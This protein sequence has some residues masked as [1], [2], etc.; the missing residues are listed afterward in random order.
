MKRGNK[1]NRNKAIGGILVGITAAAI[2]GLVLKHRA[3]ASPAP[4]SKVYYGDLRDR[5][6][7]ML[8]RL[9]EQLQS[10]DIVQESVIV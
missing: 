2:I 10:F 5:Y 6:A 3:D 1:K 7:V 8:D 9:N 4:Y